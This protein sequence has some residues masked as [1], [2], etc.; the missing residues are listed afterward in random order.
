MA[1]EI[2]RREVIV[3]L[4]SA[5]TWPRAASGQTRKADFAR[6]PSFA[7]GSQSGGQGNAMGTYG[8][9]HRER[10]ISRY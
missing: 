7:R 10:Q 6:Y 1:I 9:R 4:G 3:T 8:Q 5:V 2:R